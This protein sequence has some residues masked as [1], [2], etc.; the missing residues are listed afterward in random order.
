VS[1]TPAEA[2]ITAD[3]AKNALKDIEQTENRAAASQH[4]R[5][6]APHLLIWGVIWAIGYTVNDFAPGFSWVWSPLVLAGMVASF[7]FDRQEA[8]GRV[9][10]FNW[11]YLVSA[12]TI[13]VFIFAL[14]AIMRPRDY[15][16][17]GAFFPLV[18][19]LYYTFLGIWTKGG[20]RM[21]PL[22]LALMALTLGGYWL[23][24]EHFLLWMAAVGGGGLMLGGLW[25]R[26]V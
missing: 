8:A 10:G 20:W 15:N 23:L 21:I 2:P 26:S 1:I 14:F 13:F 12:A 6:A 7:L 18:I 9:K 4:G 11:R 24:P 25:L 19:G 3:E 17:I 16:Q 22:G 5:F